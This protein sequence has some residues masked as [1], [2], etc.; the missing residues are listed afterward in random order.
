M[1]QDIESYLLE[2]DFNPRADRVTFTVIGSNG[3]EEPAVGTGVTRDVISEFWSEF[4]EMRT[5]GSDIK[6][7]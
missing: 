1:L 2:H 5:V 6:G 4:Y 7:E 3:E